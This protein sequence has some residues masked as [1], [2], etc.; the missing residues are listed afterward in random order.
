[1]EEILVYG[2]SWCPDCRR[3][4]KFLADQRVAYA[5]H[6]IEGEPDGREGRPG[7]Q[8]RQEHHPDDRVPRRIASVGALERGAGGEARPPA[9][10]DA[11]RLRPDHRG[12]WPHRS[13]D[14]DLRGAR[15]PRDADHRLE[16]PRRAG[17]RDGAARQLPRVP[18]GDRR[19]RARRPV[20]EAG[21]ALRRGD[22]AG[23]LR[24]GDLRGLGDDRRRDE[25]DVETATGDHYHAR[26]VLLATGSSYRRTDADGRGRP[27]RR[28]HPLLRDVRRAL[29]QGLRRADGDRRGQLRSRGGRLPDPV[30]GQ[31][32]D[33]RARGPAARVED[34]AGQ[35]RWTIRGW[36]SSCGTA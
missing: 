6:D 13:D 17:G 30:H 12:R 29:L 19:R 34:P 28:G 15:E 22:A 35:G 24:H 10:G 23:G 14:L 26:A 2:A 18:G 33:R 20:R 31:G 27:D 5:W 7:S 9:T 3:A 11:A 16:G 8:R 25:L 36:R 4:K 21:R 1:M 32:H